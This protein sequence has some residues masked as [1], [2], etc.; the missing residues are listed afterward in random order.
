VDL[1]RWFHPIVVDMSHTRVGADHIGE[2]QRD[3]AHLVL[4]GSRHTILQRPAHRRTKLERRNSRD[5]FRKFL[6]QH[7]LQLVMQAFARIKILGDDDELGEKWIGELHIQCEDEADRAAANIGAEVID[8]GIAVQ[9]L[10]EAPGLGFCGVNGRVLPQ[11]KVDSQL[12]PVRRREELALHN[13][14]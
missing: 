3:L 1:P 8:I 12:R 11:G 7:L 13:T 6:G 14:G 9:Y 4:V 2:V 10:L 5:D